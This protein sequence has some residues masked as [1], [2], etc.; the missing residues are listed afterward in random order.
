MTKDQAFEMGLFF[1]AI[2]PFITQCTGAEE[3]PNLN[4]FKK[5]PNV[6]HPGSIGS[7]M[8]ALQVLCTK[9]HTYVFSQLALSKIC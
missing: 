8:L 2:G 9:E 4:P 1:T 7:S 5:I 3:R 6:L